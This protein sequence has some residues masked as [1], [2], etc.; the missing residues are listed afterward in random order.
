MRIVGEDEV[1]GIGDGCGGKEERMLVSVRIRPLNSMEVARNE[2]SVWECI[3]D[4]TIMNQNKCFYEFDRVFGCECSTK[5]VYEDA[6]KEVVLSVVNGVNSSVFVYGQTSSGKTYTMNGITECSVADIY[7]YIERHEEREFVLKFSAIEIYNEVVR[8]LLSTDARPLR[9]LD[10]PERGTIVEKLRE[11]TVRNKDHLKALLLFCQAQRQIGET[12]LNE[13]SSRSHQILRL[14]IQNSARQHLD[15][16]SFSTLSASVNFIDLAGSER[17]SQAFSEGTRLKEG[18]HINRSLLTLG[19][20]IRKLSKGRNGHIPYRDSKLTRILQSSLGGNA[21]T[22][23]ICTISPAQSHFEQSRNTLLFATCAREVV[24]SAHVNAVMSDKAMA[25]HLQKKLARLETELRYTSSASGTFHSEALRER[26]ARIRKMEK[27][28]KELIQ[29]R[30]LAQSRLEDL[31][32]VVGD[33]QASREWDELSQLSASYV[34]NAYDDVLSASDTTFDPLR[35][36]YYTSPRNLSIGPMSNCVLVTRQ[37]T[38]EA[39]QDSYSDFEDLCKEVQCIEVVEQKTSANK[40]SNP[41]LSVGHQKHA[42]QGSSFNTDDNLV[43]LCPNEVSALSLMKEEEIQNVRTNGTDTIRVYSDESYRSLAL[44]KSRSCRATVM[45]SQCVKDFHARPQGIYQKHIALGSNPEQKASNDVFKKP[46]KK[47]VSEDNITSI[48]EFVTELKEIAQ[49]Q[50]QKTT[51]DSQEL[52]QSEDFGMTSSVKDI[53]LDPMTNWL[54]EFEKRR[55]EIIELWHACNVSLIHRTYFFLL[56]K[57]DLADSVYMEVERRRLLFLK[58][59]FFSSMRNL[60]REREMLCR[61]MRRRLSAIER[62]RLYSKWGV[63]LCSKKRRMQL[64]NLLWSET[65]N[66]EHVRESA[67]QVAKLTGFL[68]PEHALKEMFGLSFTP[69]LMY[70]RSCSCRNGLYSNPNSIQFF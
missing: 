6:A 2:S 19:T 8:D 44:R 31:L 26:D 48:C 49:V 39:E 20:V 61:Q 11:E 13:M 46:N 53:G 16:D 67:S 25:N 55:K 63:E 70:T 43:K 22:A 32:L 60:R 15:K 17:A 24:T 29:Q 65:E 35:E 12:S 41:L 5:Q 68:K 62:E 58:D 50:Y 14:T 47:C 40:E 30:D 38:E 52:E 36:E 66:T 7:E 64:A 51:T 33:E 56:F 69:Q 54:M 42:S 27:E 57:G 21:R 4:T 28:M 1:M 23:I 18:S 9:V 37:G 59:T 45:P 10:D 34:S 3:S